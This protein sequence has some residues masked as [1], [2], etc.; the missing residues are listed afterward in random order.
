[1][2]VIILYWIFSFLWTIGFDVYEGGS[3][4]KNVLIALLLGWIILPISYGSK[5]SKE[6]KE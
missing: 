6:I 3:N 2:E 5:R 1:M 4:V